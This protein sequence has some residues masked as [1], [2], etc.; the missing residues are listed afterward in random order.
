MNGQTIISA[1][2]HIPV[3]PVP[4]EFEDLDNSCFKIRSNEHKDDDQNRDLLASEREREGQPQ[5]NRA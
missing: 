5:S 3:N 4:I 2:G 1:G